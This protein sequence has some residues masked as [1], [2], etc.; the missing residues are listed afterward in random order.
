MPLHAVFNVVEIACSPATQSNEHGALVDAKSAVVHPG[1]GVL[2]ALVHE[3]EKPLIC[4]NWESV[5]NEVAAP[6]TEE[7]NKGRNRSCSVAGVT[8]VK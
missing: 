3:A 6:E 8:D 1:I 2:Y 5:T 4:W 7:A